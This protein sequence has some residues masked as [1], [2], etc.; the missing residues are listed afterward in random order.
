MNILF[1]VMLFAPLFGFLVSFLG[2]CFR[3]EWQFWAYIPL[4]FMAVSFISYLVSWGAYQS[5]DVWVSSTLRWVDVGGFHLD[6]GLYYDALSAVMVGVVL[7]VSLC[8]HAYSLEYMSHNENCGRFMSYLSF[9]TFMMLLLIMSPNLVQ[10]FIGWEGVGLASYL[11]IGFWHHKPQATLAAQKAFIVNRIADVGFLIGVL[12]SWHFFHSVDLATINSSLPSVTHSPHLWIVALGFTVAAMGK[13]AQFGLHVWLPDAMEGP[14]PVSALIHA[15]TMV[16][17]GI[18]LIVRLSPVFELVPLVKEALVYIG[19]V[20]TFFAGTVALAQRD[21]KRIIAYSTCSQLGMMMMACG[22]GAYSVA[23]FHLVTHAYFK[24]LL[25]LGAGSVIHALSD[26]QDIFNMGGLWRYIPFTYLCMWIGSLSLI[27]APYFAGYFSKEAIMACLFDA[28][29]K[30]AFEMGLVCVL[31]TALYSGRL[32]FVVFHSTCRAHE[33]VIAHVHE[34]KG[35]MRGS[36]ICLSVGALASGWIGHRLLLEQDWGFG[37]GVSLVFTPIIAMPTWA[38]WSPTL[39]AFGGML[40]AFLIYG[41]RSLK[42]SIIIKSRSWTAWIYKSLVEKWW[43]DHF[44]NFTAVR[45][46]AWLSRCSAHFDMLF[47]NYVPDGS[48]AVARVCGQQLRLLHT[49]WLY[50]MVTWMLVSFILM[51]VWGNMCRP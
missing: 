5:G 1:F 31:L 51:L 49:S 39:I 28:P 45:F 25:F 36:L 15:A 30:G 38:H 46:H 35:W 2:T 42:G 50:D 17:A 4:G 3:R 13:S 34:A 10:M 44:Y 19:L 41:R 33:R 11:L 22:C 24:A 12:G 26:E 32:L 21:I 7:S 18:F 8:V 6:W 14:T 23:I 20:T 40:L 27:G 47:D 16:T 29:V 43:V 9:F 48:V 37:W